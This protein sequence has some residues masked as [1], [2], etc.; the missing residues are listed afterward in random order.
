MDEHR[1]DPNPKQP[2]C[3]GVIGRVSNLEVSSY[4]RLEGPEGNRVNGD[5][6]RR[7]GCPEEEGRCEGEEGE[8][9]GEVE[10]NNFIFS[11]RC[12]HFIYFF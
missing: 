3:R 2:I 11:F 10:V 6:P 8:G 4:V 7:V 12:F 5:P 9:G 1:G